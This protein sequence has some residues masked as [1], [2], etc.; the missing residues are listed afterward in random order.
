M[1][2]S[3]LFPVLLVFA[4]NSC[5]QAPNTTIKKE[6][7]RLWSVSDSLYLDFLNFKTISEFDEYQYVHGELFDSIKVIASLEGQNF[8]LVADGDRLKN[9]LICILPLPE[10]RIIRFHF[11]RNGAVIDYNGEQIEPEESKEIVIKRFTEAEYPKL[12]VISLVF[13]DSIKP[14]YVRKTLASINDGVM[15]FALGGL[16]PDSILL[17][18]DTLEQLI[19]PDFK[20]YRLIFGIGKFHGN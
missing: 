6:L 2:N 18:T 12:Q 7:L 15:T 17:N 13:E 16:S 8:E 14:D 3:I 19:K 1:K 11:S 9:D 10:H 4:I 5:N 20:E